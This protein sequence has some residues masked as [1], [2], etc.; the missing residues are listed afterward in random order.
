M[1]E[2][3]DICGF[4]YESNAHFCGK[5]GVDLREPKTDDNITIDTTPSEPVKKKQKSSSKKEEVKN[6]SMIKWCLVSALCNS[7][8]MT[9]PIFFNLV[10]TLAEGKKQLG[11]CDCPS[12]NRG[13]RELLAVVTSGTEKKK[14]T[15][16]SREIVIKARET[17]IDGMKFDISGFLSRENSAGDDRPKPGN[18]LPKKEQGNTDKITIEIDPDVLENAVFNILKSDKGRVLIQ[19]IKKQKRRIEV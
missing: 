5:C 9:F 18:E 14:L 4:K 12:C 6:D 19:Q 16:S 10:L 8:E 13:Y 1:V 15:A 17:K 11:F 7:Y 2:E 3:C